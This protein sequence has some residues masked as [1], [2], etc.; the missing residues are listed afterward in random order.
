LTAVSDNVS[1]KLIVSTTP[2]ADTA[3]KPWYD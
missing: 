1:Q 3:V 2:S